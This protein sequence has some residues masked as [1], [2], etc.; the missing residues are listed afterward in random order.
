MFSLSITYL[1]KK[2][3]EL[4]W[5]EETSAKC[6]ITWHY[7][8]INQIFPNIFFCQHIFKQM[9]ILF[10]GLTLKVSKIYL[11]P[12]TI[13]SN[14]QLCHDKHCNSKFKKI[15]KYLTFSLVLTRTFGTDGG[16]G[17]AAFT[18]PELQALFDQ[19]GRRLTA[20]GNILLNIP[21]AGARI[22]IDA[23]NV[24]TFA[25]ALASRYWKNN[26]TMTSRRYLTASKQLASRQSGTHLLGQ[27]GTH[28]RSTLCVQ[29]GTADVYSARA[30]DLFRICL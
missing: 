13:W 28:L 21:S 23:D 12:I 20:K 14:L 2:G 22:I 29:L 7:W 15:W 6:K 26:L 16:E 19:Y 10:K 4:N 8:K 30:T 1:I 25:R 11:T 5:I 27:L 17:S 18:S 24:D 3:K 9:K